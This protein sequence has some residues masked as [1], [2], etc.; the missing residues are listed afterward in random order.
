L[1]NVIL[2]MLME[3]VLKTIHNKYYII[4]NYYLLL[5]II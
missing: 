5:I 4:N 3:I 2:N 1:I